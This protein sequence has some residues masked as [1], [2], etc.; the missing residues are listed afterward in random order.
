M[1]WSM[2]IEIAGIS[3]AAA[4]Q[5]EVISGQETGI[6]SIK[7]KTKREPGY[8]GGRMSMKIMQSRMMDEWLNGYDLM[9]VVM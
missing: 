5:I 6:S 4:S 3:M 7:R 9:K 8:E 1:K 2:S